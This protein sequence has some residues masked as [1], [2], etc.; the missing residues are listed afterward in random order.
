MRA[1]R[2][3]PRLTPRESRI[4][5]AKTVQDTR[6]EIRKIHWPSR[7]ETTRL[8]IVVIV[9]SIALA[10]FLGVMVD[11]V[12]SRLFQFLIGQF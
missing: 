10:I 4:N 12:F 6:A 2:S 7:E 3:R 9:L 8:T 11:Y 1:L 5:A